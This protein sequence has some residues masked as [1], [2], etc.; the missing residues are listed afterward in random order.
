MRKIIFQLVITLFGVSNLLQAQT[1]IKMKKEGGIYTTPCKV[2]GLKLRFIVDTGASDVSISS[3]E[4]L[5]MLKND[6]LSADDFTGTQKYKV[7]N[8]EIQE[9]YTFIIRELE[10]GDITVR[11]VSASIVKN[12]DA[13]LLLGQSALSKF[14][15]VSFDYATETLYLG[16]GGSTPNTPSYTTNGTLYNTASVASGS[17]TE[18]GI[19]PLFKMIAIPAGTFT[20]GCT[21]EQSY[22]ESNEKPTHSV[23]LS[24]FKMMETEVTQAQWRA[25]MG[26]NPSSFSGCDDCPVEN[27]SWDDIQT[28]LSKLNTKCG[29]RYRLPTEAEWEYAARGGQDYQYAGSNNIDD[30]AWCWD[31]WGRD[32]R[33]THSVKGK[34]ANGYGL[35]DMSGN[36]AEWCS[37]GYGGGDWKGSFYYKNSP[38]SNPQGENSDVLRVIRGGC[39]VCG[40]I[41]CRVTYR[42]GGELNFHHYAYGFRL[43]SSL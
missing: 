15:R 21:S 19:S 30:V 24:A 43:V 6:Y 14:G 8:G 20:M 35:Y 10:I 11:N 41:D 13:P 3:T 28:F 32:N 40:K 36:V 33:K 2:N 9:G 5:F 1:A 39:W 34:R 18:Y 29:K 25:V 12:L 31:N 37:D 27:V 26:S 7:A 42:N 38:Y 17:Y 16:T 23:S 22:C 4:A